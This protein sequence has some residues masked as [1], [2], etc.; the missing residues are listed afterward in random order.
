M[1]SGCPPR[2]ENVEAQFLPLL[3][4]IASKRSLPR[5]VACQKPMKTGTLRTTLMVPGRSGCWNSS[6]KGATSP[7][8]EAS[9]I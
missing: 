9:A 7:K 1:G 3:Q 6:L 8:L 2:P 4:S 5:S